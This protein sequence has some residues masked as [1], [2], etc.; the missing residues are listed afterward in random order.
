MSSAPRISVVVTCHNL[1]AYLGDAVDSVLAQTLQDFELLI[2]DDGSTEPETLRVLERYDRPPARVLRTENRGLPGARNFGLRQARGG[3]VCCLDGD[4]LLLPNWLERAAAVLDAEPALAFVSH[5]LHAFGDREWD[6]TPE[7]CDFPALLD[8]NTVNGAAL[9]RREALLAVG[10]Y[11]ET[12][13]QGC[14]DWELWVRMTAR[15]HRGTILKEVH[16]LYRQRPDSMTRA[17]H[18]GAMHPALF[19]EIVRRS[20]PAFREHLGPLLRRRHREIVD[21]RRTGFDLDREFAE[22][23][24]PERAFWQVEV[25]ARK[26]K[27]ERLQE[28]RGLRERAS[29]AEAG[30]GAAQAEAE[31][32]RRSELEARAEAAALRASASWRVTAPLRAVHRALT[33][34]FG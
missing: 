5:W 13:R 12:M 9:V 20:E 22:V 30:L 25:E 11:D 3:Y 26:R 21:L 14:E 10:G 2:V 8:R 17:M 4:D 23:R 24:G 18:R 16:F 7:S 28:A 32:L 33:R 19:A 27:L 1:G 6:F 29:E 34:L 15:G 31:V